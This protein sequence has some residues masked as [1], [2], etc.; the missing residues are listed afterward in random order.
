MKVSYDCLELLDG[1]HTLFIDGKNHWL[2]IYLTKKIAD[3][4]L[5]SCAKF[6]R[7]Q[8]IDDWVDCRVA[9]SQPA[10]SCQLAPRKAESARQSYK[11]PKIG[12]YFIRFW[13]EKKCVLFC[14]ITV[15]TRRRR[16]RGDLGHSR[17]RQ[18]WMMI[19]EMW[20]VSIFFLRNPH[21]SPIAKSLLIL[22][23]GR[24]WK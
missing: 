1:E 9:V 13:I 6:S 19:W 23:Q 4:F 5:K 8:T 11:V 12:K 10:V 7:K 15:V 16:R 14:W 2:D 3:D 18:P 20:C 24:N 21:L 17:D 22:Q